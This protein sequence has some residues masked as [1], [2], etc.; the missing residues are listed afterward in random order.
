MRR[1]ADGFY[2]HILSA[3]GVSYVRELGSNAQAAVGPEHN[4]ALS[5]LAHGVPDE[6]PLNG[7]L[8]DLFSR[9]EAEGAAVRGAP[10]VD[11]RIEAQL[12]DLG[13]GFGWFVDEHDQAA[14]L[15]ALLRRAHAR[16][17][18]FFPEIGQTPVMPEVAAFRCLELHRLLVSQARVI[19][20]GD[21][22][23]LSLGMAFLG[24][25]PYAVDIDPLL[26]SFLKAVAEEEGLVVEAHVQDLLAP[27]PAALRGAFDAG[28]SDPMSFENC[29]LAFLSRACSALREGGLLWS[30][31]HPVARG[32]CERVFA[33]LPLSLART[34]AAKNVYY[35]LKYD[36]SPYRSDLVLLERTG[37][38][39]PWSPDERI[40]YSHVT[41]GKLKPVS[42]AA[43]EARGVR[44]RGRGPV[45]AQLLCEGI[46]GA[47]GEP[48]LSKGGYEDDG[49]A[50]AFV[51]FEGGQVAVT[52]EHTRTRLRLSL[53]P[54][55][56]VRYA[57]IEAAALEVLRPVLRWGTLVPAF[58]HPPQPLAK[59]HAQE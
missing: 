25:R 26:V 14:A 51:A 50:H 31:V 54:H 35:W 15:I 59:G 17:K 41:D 43:L 6:A 45:S 22:D 1:L 3:E 23:L 19:H 38:E 7:P 55:D 12:S 16:R 24:H 5:R 37:G 21:D 58:E 27:F 33:R 57:R 42:H 40:P 11:P 4:D 44:S 47:L 36:E 49:Y 18:V 53:Y 9:L 28:F 34:Y 46:A 13:G 8:K 29:Q 39:P 10:A 20:I 52:F 30:T 56:P 32:V 2:A 48:A